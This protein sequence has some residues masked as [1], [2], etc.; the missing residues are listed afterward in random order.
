MG[1]DGLTPVH[2]FEVNFP[3][4]EKAENWLKSKFWLNSCT[5]RNTGA[6]ALLTSNTT[7]PVCEDATY[8]VVPTQYTECTRSTGLL[9]PISVGITAHTA[10]KASSTCIMYLW[11]VIC[12]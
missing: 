10:A 2:R 8:A 5:P 6:A 12:C 1:S 7:S 11:Y 9:L 3:R 4:P